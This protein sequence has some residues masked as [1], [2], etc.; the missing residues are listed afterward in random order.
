[1]FGTQ[2]LLLPTNSVVFQNWTVQFRVHYKKQIPLAHTTESN[3]MWT[4]KI[5]HITTGGGGVEKLMGGA[6]AAGCFGRRRGQPRPSHNQP[7][8]AHVVGGV[9][10]AACARKERR[11]RKRRDIWRGGS[12]ENTLNQQRSPVAVLSCSFIPGRPH[13]RPPVL[14][15]WSEAR[16]AGTQLL[17]QMHLLPI[18][19]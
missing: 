17:Q 4:Q 2:F 14:I 8:Q 3:H 12:R 6:A 19:S 5:I 1:M 13:W 11:K 10:L 18:S 16:A 9:A 7:R 15:L